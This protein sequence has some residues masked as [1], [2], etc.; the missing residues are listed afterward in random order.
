MTAAMCM[1]GQCDRPAQVRI[2]V[3]E[4]TR[5]ALAHGAFCVPH[6][7]LTSRA[8]HQ[9]SGAEVWFDWLR[10]DHDLDCACDPLDLSML[11]AG[12]YGAGRFGGE[13]RLRGFEG[14]EEAD[15]LE[16]AR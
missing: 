1:W 14:P 6:S 12:D 5:G 4:R 11:P 10:G 2:V 16:W 7:A 8:L 3:R 13:P 15:P 9:K